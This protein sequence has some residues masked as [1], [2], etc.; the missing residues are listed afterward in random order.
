MLDQDWDMINGYHVQEY[1]LTPTVEIYPDLIPII[2]N[3]TEF[4]PI[5]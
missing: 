3:F 1:Y 2:E 5:L 4:V